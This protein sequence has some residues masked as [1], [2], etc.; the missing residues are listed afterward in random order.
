MYKNIESSAVALTRLIKKSD[1]WW[2]ESACTLRM[3][4]EP[5]SYLPEK[6]VEW[7]PNHNE[8]DIFAI[9]VDGPSDRVLEPG[10][11]ISGKII[12]NPS[13]NFEFSKV[14]VAF[15]LVETIRESKLYGESQMN[16]K[17]TLCRMEI[18]PEVVPREKIFRR[19]Y[20]YTYFFSLIAPIHLPE[21]LCS[22]SIA[23]HLRL[24]PSVGNSS[25]PSSI[26]YRVAGQIYKSM[27]TPVSEITKTI[28]L[29]ASYRVAPEA[30]ILTKFQSIGEVKKGKLKKSSL[31]VCELTVTNPPVIQLTSHSPT[32]F[33]V[34][35]RFTP[36]NGTI[37]AQKALSKVSYK[38]LANTL[39]S[40]N[41]LKHSPKKGEDGVLI[42][43]DT[44]TAQ[45]LT[46][47]ALRWEES[48]TPNGKASYTSTLQLPLV[49]PEC[50]HR[51]IIPAFSTCHT[52][53]TYSLLISTRWNKSQCVLEVPVTINADA[54]SPSSAPPS[55]TSTSSR[56]RAREIRLA[57]SFS[58]HAPSYDGLYPY[59]P[60]HYTT[61]PPRERLNLP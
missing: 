51:A 41:H 25:G 29:C 18:P 17:Y 58:G 12:I 21:S 56:S 26:S 10:S 2:C 13:M 5:P 49:L 59:S 44:V 3:M 22:D 32:V 23:A 31:G 20:K 55:L 60:P 53:L 48:V 50:K 6:L 39:M 45:K 34:K 8:A 28:P 36:A 38:L 9:E 57:N 4:E 33:D 14:Q 35:L 27:S 16:R 7:S 37:A 11:I 30:Y 54:Y 61:I 24:P 15:Q 40:S 47:P 19:A 52:T 46:V 43:V 1:Y 42:S